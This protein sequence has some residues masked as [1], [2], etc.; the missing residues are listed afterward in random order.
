MKSIPKENIKHFT[1]TL[2]AVIIGLY[3]HSKFVEPKINLKKTK[4]TKM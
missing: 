4:A 1:I 3:V 2:A